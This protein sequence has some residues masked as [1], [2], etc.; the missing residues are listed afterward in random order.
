MAKLSVEELNNKINSL[1][2]DDDV[3]IE[4]LE[5]VTDSFTNDNSEE[6]DKIK[7]ELFDLKEK[8]KQRFLSSDEKKEEKK[9]DELEEKEVI[10]VKEI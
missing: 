9:D 5:D 8:Y 2:I 1:E 3:K 4:L 7:S 6:L 10:D